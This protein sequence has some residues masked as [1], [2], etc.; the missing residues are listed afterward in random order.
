MH[1][2]NLSNNIRSTSSPKVK[3]LKHATCDANKF[4]SR[5]I[6]DGSY[7]IVGMRFVGRVLWEREIIWKGKRC[8]FKLPV[9]SQQD[10]SSFYSIALT[11]L[12][13]IPVRVVDS[14]SGKLIRPSVFIL[15]KRVFPCRLKN[16]IRIAIFHFSN[17]HRYP[18]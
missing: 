6:I 12:Y 14:L 9:G 18:A 15:Q 1:R 16:S 8:I 4:E 7:V 3:S 17:V 11:S 5:E 2:D 10:L 13:F